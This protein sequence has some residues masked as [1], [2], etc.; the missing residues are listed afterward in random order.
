MVKKNEL[1]K[2]DK[3]TE[4]IILDAAKKVFLVKGFDGARMQEIADEA[5]INKHWC[6]IILEVKK[7]YSM[8]FLKKL[9]NSLCLKWPK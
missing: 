7:I 1:N 3:N 8:L 2:N 5:G 6:I 9:F 4:K